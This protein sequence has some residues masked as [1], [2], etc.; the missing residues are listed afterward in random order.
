MYAKT[1]RFTCIGPGAN[2]SW[3]EHSNPPSTLLHVPFPQILD[4]AHSLSSEHI[5]K[6]KTHLKS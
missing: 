3:Q 1:T 5:Q 2:P 6:E 4:T